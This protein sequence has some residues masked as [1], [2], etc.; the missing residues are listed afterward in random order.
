MLEPPPKVWKLLIFPV[1]AIAFFLAMFLS[2]YQFFYRG[3]YTPPESPEIYFAEIVNNPAVPEDFTDQPVFAA[4]PVGA[5]NRG[6]LL[7]DVGHRN[8]FHPDEI[9]TLIDRMSDRGYAVQFLLEPGALALAEGLRGADAFAVISPIESYDRE[10]ANLVVDFVER[11]G[12]LLLVAD[13]GRPQRINSLSEMLGVSFQPDYLYNLAEHDSNFQEFYIRD[14]RAHTVT[15][16]IEE[17]IFYYAGSIESSG[18]VL[19]LT[20]ANTYSSIAERQDTRSPL[21]VGAYRNV[22]AVHDLTF[23]IPP[24]NAVRD[25]DRLVSNIAD[26]LTEGQKA[27]HLADFPGFFRD[28]VDLLLGR[29][30]LFDLSAQV[31]QLLADR[32]IPSEL[33]KVENAGRDT[34]FLGLYEDN[35]AVARYLDSAG[36]RIGDSLTTPFASGVPL[37]G[38]AVLQLHRAGDRDVLIILADTPEGLEKMV[39]QLSTGEFRSGLTDDFAG[40]YKTE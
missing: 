17:M 30:D 39:R 16:G 37:E 4:N 7:V 19:A 31:K 14:F 18:A 23:M 6:A 2:A 35:P 26:F 9:A 11:G 10:E 34:V 38:T 36:I 22:L 12:N 8:A 3:G 24:Y 25:N 5:T 20:D 21:A 33:Q 15:E 28:D 29:P 27:Y 13:P 40:V 1:F 32:G